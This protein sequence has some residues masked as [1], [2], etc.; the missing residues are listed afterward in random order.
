MSYRDDERREV[1]QYFFNDPEKGKK[2]SEQI[3]EA[4]REPH[5]EHQQGK[6]EAREEDDSGP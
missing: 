3:R 6:R 5:D 2:Y 4:I 1:E